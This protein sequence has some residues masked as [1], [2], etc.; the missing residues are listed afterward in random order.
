M[1]GEDHGTAEV[2]KFCAALFRSLV[3]MGFQTIVLETGPV[4]TERLAKWV[5]APGGRAQFAAFE[6]K[7]PGTTAFYGWG[8]EFDFLRSSYD[9][10]N[11]RLRLWGI[12]QELMGAP[13]FLFDEM[14]ATNPGPKS[15]ALIAQ[16]S[17]ENSDDLAAAYK[18]GN[19][20]AMFAMQASRDELVALQTSLH[21]DG[22]ARAQHL[23]GALLATRD[24][25]IN[26]CN[27]HAPQSNRDRALLMKASLAAYLG[28]DTAPGR[29][30]KLFFKF[31]EEHMYRGFNPI[32]NN[33]VGNTMAEIADTAGLKDVHILMLGIEGT[34]TA[35]AGIGKWASPPYSLM[36]DDHA[37]FHFLKPFVDAADR[38]GLTLYDMRPLRS[39]FA[40]MGI[41]DPNYERLVFGYDFLVLAGK[42]T[43][44]APIDPTIF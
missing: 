18:T 17:K 7:Y 2:P 27:E 29:L 41:T 10:T 39:H 11:G 15:T 21:A 34:Q 24:I 36:D 23:A 42:T 3:P 20:G 16:L 9:A 25:Y 31:G 1:V 22:N 33:D 44:D 4:V 43:P 26:C 5:A 13:G 38:N 32:R 30:P 6:K 35:F 19:P 12:D 40:S 8:G 37:R 14:L 28:D